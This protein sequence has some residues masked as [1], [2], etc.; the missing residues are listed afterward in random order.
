MSWCVGG[1]VDREAMC[2]NL[3]AEGCR[4]VGFTALTFELTPLEWG[5]SRF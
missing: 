5:Q 2:F 1:S 3:V 4:V